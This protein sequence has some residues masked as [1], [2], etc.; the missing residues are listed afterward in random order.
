MITEGAQQLLTV[1]CLQVSKGPVCLCL[2][3]RKSLKFCVGKRQSSNG[4]W[5]LNLSCL[6]NKLLFQAISR[7]RQMQPNL[8]QLLYG[9]FLMTLTLFVF[10]C[11]CS[12][13]GFFFNFFF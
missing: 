5:E 1:K 11:T 13:L 7:V 2:S 9:F 8:L 12:A 6:V 3:A 10:N 4:T